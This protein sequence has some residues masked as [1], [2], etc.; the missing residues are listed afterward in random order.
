[1]CVIGCEDVRSGA[2][3][4]LVVSTC[5]VSSTARCSVLQCVAVC[6]SVLQCVVVSCSVVQCVTRRL[7]AAIIVMCRHVWCV[8]WNVVV[9]QV[10]DAVWCVWLMQCGACGVLGR[11][12]SP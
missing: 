8:W 5:V 1:M 6:C 10:A 11:F 4:S 2:Y 3:S 7:V 12:L 9:V